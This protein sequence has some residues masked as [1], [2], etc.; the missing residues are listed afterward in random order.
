MRRMSADP[1]APPSRAHV[2]AL[3]ACGV[4]AVLH[5]ATHWDWFIEDAAICFAFARNLAMGEGAVAVWGG[6]RVEA[7]SDPAWVAL[8]TVF[9]WKGVDGW[10]SSKPLAMGFGLVSVWVAW[11]LAREALPEHRGPGALIAPILVALHAQLAIWSASGL[12]NGMFACVLGLAVWRTVVETRTGGPPWSAAWYLLL[13]WTRPEG[14]LYAFAGAVWWFAAAR[15]DRRPPRQVLGWL[16]V[17]VLPSL[18]LEAGRLAYFAWPLPNTAYAKVDAPLLW[19]LD[20]NEN[21][22]RQLRD[23]AD[24]GWHAW[25][26]PVYAVG[27]VGTSGPRARLALGVVAALAVTLLWPGPSDLQR[28]PIWP[29]LGEPPELLRYARSAAL[30]TATAV[31][32]LLAWGRPGGVARGACGHAAWVGLAFAVASNGDWMGGFRWMSLFAVPASVLLAVGLVDVADRLER[33]ATGSEVWSQTGWLAVAF[34]VGLWIPPNLSL[35]RDHRLFNR[36]V[37]PF[38]IKP[39][40]D[41]FRGVVAR[42]FHEGPVR[43][44]EIDQGAFLWWAPD[45]RQHD[46]AMLVD[47]PLAR[48]WWQQRAFVREYLFEEVRPTFVNI[49]INNGWTRRSGLHISYPEW[50]EQLFH[51]PGYWNADGTRFFGTFAQRSL[52]MTDRWEQAVDRAVGFE[53]GWTLVG[54]AQPAVWESG[55]HGYLEAPVASDRPRPL[56]EGASTVAFLVTDGRVV[57]WDLPLGYGFYPLEDWVPGQVFR[58]RHALPVPADLPPGRY[59]LGF[60]FLSAGEGVRRPTSVPPGAVVGGLDGAPAV[61][62]AGEVRFPDAIE[63]VAPAEVDRQQQDAL[64]AVSAFAG[65][66]RCEDAEAAWLQF[67]RL[68]PASGDGHRSER[69]A[70]AAGVAD[71][72]ARRA[73]VA[74][75]DAVASLER[76]HDWDHWSPEL[77]RV[78][79]SVA[80]ALLA[81]AH[82]ARAAGDW[83]VAYRAFTDV[84]RFQPW[85]A[86]ARRYAEEARDHRLG[87]HDDVRIGRRGHEDEL[88][89]LEAAQAADPAQG[90]P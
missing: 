19:V 42:T 71:C 53:S 20:W 75:Q 84:L 55:G 15:R 72:W 90:T 86:W 21:G 44:L 37:T 73:E 59:E 27:L 3:A 66:G 12:E 68:R 10:T 83:E 26:V 18:A 56:E 23:W 7:F 13:A 1:S 32:P 54:F 24:R 45:F 79:E 60:L 43:N 8:L 6:E 80:T 52:V 57:S 9:H 48:H 69:A 31:L 62:A 67:K 33:V 40:V 28:L 22:W 29:E 36:D 17:L 76:A 11:R 64:A 35:T 74:P 5:Q 4:V 77:A 34:G 81:R 51:L 70:I 61:V 30:F 63:V 16:A 89:A 85:R 65:A 2:L 38:M 82:A 41:Y 14:V 50:D 88:R 78:G 46:L 87:L 58:G 47:V 25:W 49:G 39:R